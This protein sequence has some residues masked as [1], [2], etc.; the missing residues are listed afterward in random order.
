MSL[1]E[2][3]ILFA[4]TVPVTLIIGSVLGLLNYKKLS[5]IYRVLLL[6]IVL[7]LL[8]DITARIL[9]EI[10]NNNL[11]ITMGFPLIEIILFTFLY[12]KQL[13]SKKSI[14]LLTLS[15]IGSIYCLYEISNFRMS[16]VT[17]FT[18]YSKTFINITI[19][20][21]CIKYF[22]EV[23]EKNQ[24][25]SSGISKL[26]SANLLFFSYSVIYFIPINFLINV[27]W[28]LKYWF[29]FVNILVH[30]AYY[31]FISREIWK[32]GLNHKL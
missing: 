4:Y 7:S 27:S 19:I 25:I 6:F 18:S 22:F 10:Y 23:I 2:F 14:P 9:G 11:I 20:A 29:W 28:D 32:N 3:S 12:Q 26:N 8:A 13:F 16:N 21:M 30:L 15:V 5:P 31:I 24:T 1:L 17:E